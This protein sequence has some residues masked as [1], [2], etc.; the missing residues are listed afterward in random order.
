MNDSMYELAG[1]LR[2]QYQQKINNIHIWTSVSHDALQA[3]SLNSDF[4]KTGKFNVPSSSKTKGTK[5]KSIKRSS[6]TVKRILNQA[7]SKD[8]YHLV[9]TYIVTQIEAFFS[10]LVTGVLIRDTRRLKTN[11]KGIDQA[12]KI[13]IESIVDSSSLEEV[14]NKIIEKETIGLFYASPLKQREYFKR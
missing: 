7:Q 11:V 12:N 9:Q 4:L 10:D 8:F 14:F 13:E 1:I 5:T 6:D 3:A 2:T